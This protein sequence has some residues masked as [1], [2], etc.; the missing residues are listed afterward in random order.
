MLGTSVLVAV[1]V[2]VAEVEWF[3]WLDEVTAA[4]ADECAGL[5]FGYEC[6]AEGSACVVVSAGFT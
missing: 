2:V 6:F 1:V 5:V 3:G 4:P